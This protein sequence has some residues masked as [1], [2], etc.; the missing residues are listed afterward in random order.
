MSG[1][2]WAGKKEGEKG[3]AARFRAGLGCNWQSKEEDRAMEE[4]RKG[5]LRK[6]GRRNSGGGAGERRERLGDDEG[7]FWNKTLRGCGFHSPKYI[8]VI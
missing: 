7:C 8:P 3:T 5:E 1:R 4:R 2:V 6:R